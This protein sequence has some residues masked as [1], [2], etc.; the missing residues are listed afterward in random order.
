MGK[1]TSPRSASAS[2][3]ESDAE[4]V[5]AKKTRAAATEELELPKEDP[6]NLYQRTQNWNFF[7]EEFKKF[8][9][10]HGHGNLRTSG[11]LATPLGVWVGRQRCKY[12]K[13][14][15]YSSRLTKDQIQRLNSVGFLWTS[16]RTDAI[17][18]ERFQELRAYKKKHG[19]TKVQWGDITTGET[20][21]LGIWGT[22][23]L[24][25]RHHYANIRM[26]M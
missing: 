21:P 8:R 4:K 5:P 20:T 26:C 3:D 22:F 12:S 24:L 6:E 16:T 9:E 10:T 18:E 17:F 11:E 14:N 1:T 25:L 7:F 13:N 15:H 19:H 2:D 23:R